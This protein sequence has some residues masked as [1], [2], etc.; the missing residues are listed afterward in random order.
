MWRQTYTAWTYGNGLNDSPPH[1]AAQNLHLTLDRQISGQTRSSG[2][3]PPAYF[4]F[5]F[6][7]GSAKPARLESMGKVWSMT[8]SR[9]KKRKLEMR[10]K[11]ERI[12]HSAPQCRPLASSREPKPRY[13]LANV[14]RM[15]VVSVCLHNGKII[16]LPWK[17]PLTNWKIR[18]RSIICT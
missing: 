8:W 16:W 9:R 17:R 18:Y 2:S 15:H 5:L 14:Q 1:D 10:G 7:V 13:H 6:P 4:Y 3:H 11:A 12:A